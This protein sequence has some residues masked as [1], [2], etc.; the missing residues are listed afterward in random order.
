MEKDSMTFFLVM[1]FESESLY[2]PLNAKQLPRVTA[3]SISARKA[4][5]STPQSLPAH[6]G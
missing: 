6:S 5:T 3:P 2:R 4:F 1:V